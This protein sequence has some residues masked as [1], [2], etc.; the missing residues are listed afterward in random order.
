M[1][2][3]WV[4]SLIDDM[5][6][7]NSNFDD[8]FGVAM[9]LQSLILQIIKNLSTINVP[10]LEENTGDTAPNEFVQSP[11]NIVEQPFQAE[12]D[13]TALSEQTK[14]LYGNIPEFE[15]I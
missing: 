12:L 11:H 1:Q 7:Q 8:K 15:A 10:V 6:K 5:R 14:E 4:L 2:P 13:I 3:R 9:Q